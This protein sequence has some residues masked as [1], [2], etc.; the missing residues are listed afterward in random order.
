[1]LL[2]FFL[3]QLLSKMVR[4]FFF[5]SLHLL[6][7]KKK[8]ASFTEHHNF[9][10]ALCVYC[11]AHFFSL[12][13]NC[14]FKL[15]RITKNRQQ[16]KYLYRWNVLSY[17]HYR[18]LIT[19]PSNLKTQFIDISSFNGIFLERFVCIFFSLFIFC[20]CH[21]DCLLLFASQSSSIL[22]RFVFFFLLLLFQYLAVVFF[23]MHALNK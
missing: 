4:H 12:L 7:D 20:Q 16:N 17:S 22:L 18:P 11:G 21:C 14:N 23:Y 5:Y 6:S 9:L 19:K 10:G 1:M 3:S 8:I 13:I 2:L 15:K